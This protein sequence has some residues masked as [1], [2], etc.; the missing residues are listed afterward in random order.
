MR[1]GQCTGTIAKPGERVSTLLLICYR[2]NLVCRARPS[3][4]H[5]SILRAAGAGFVK[6]DIGRPSPI[7]LE[8]FNSSTGS[9]IKCM[10]YRRVIALVEQFSLFPVP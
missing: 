3:L 2:I 1:V 9:I 7:F 4:L 6:F 10:C 8:R 5:L